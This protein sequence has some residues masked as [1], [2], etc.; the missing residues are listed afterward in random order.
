[1]IYPTA[2]F[3]GL[4][5]LQG[6]QVPVDIIQSVADLFSTAQNL[7]YRPSGYNRFLDYWWLATGGVTAPFSEDIHDPD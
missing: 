5:D 3:T 1:M 6:D 7:A 4:A 2:I